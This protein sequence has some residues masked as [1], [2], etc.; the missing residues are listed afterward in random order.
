[1]SQR[2]F[3]IFANNNPQVDYGLVA[4]CNALMI[5]SNLKENHV[6][7]VTD[8]YTLGW[9]KESRGEEILN[10][11][12]DN[13]IVQTWDEVHGQ[14]ATT[15]RRFHD[16]LST[17]HTLPW[18]N[19]SRPD[20]YALSP[21]EETI[22]ID[23]DYLVAD[24]TLDLA[25]G[26]HEDIMINR[27]A[28]TLGHELPADQERMLDPF[29]IKMYWATCVYFRKSPTAKLLFDLVAH[30]R[31]NYEFYQ[32]VYGFKGTLYRND[33]A[34]SIALHMLNG[35]G[36]D[37]VASLPS[38]VL[39]TSFDCDELYDVPA[40]NEFIFYVNDSKDR[41]KFTLSRVKG[42]NVHVMNKFS[43]IR[44]A[45]KFLEIYGGQA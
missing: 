9:L 16:T 8:E 35:F 7:F 26:S 2:G 4:I 17:T 28:L 3:L 40:K 31:E 36:L 30:V 23:C 42:V 21:Y 19:H 24:K 37:S 45:S 38:P 20:A 18:Y 25:W 14:K 43:I 22:L 12:F 33:F 29:T 44:H 5:K 15:E 10:R 11:A 1:M 34:F 32:I 27:D 39:L 6:T 13:I 41:W